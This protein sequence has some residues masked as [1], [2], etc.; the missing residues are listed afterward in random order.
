MHPSEAEQA[1]LQKLD[2]DVRLIMVNAKVPYDVIAR[3]ADLQY[4]S[5][6]DFVELY[7]DKAVLAGEAPDE[8]GFKPGSNGYD[9]GSSKRARIR[10]SQAWDTAAMTLTTRKKVMTAASNEEV[11]S[12]VTDATRSNMEKM[13]EADHGGKKPPL[14]R[15]GSDTLIGLLL[16]KLSAE[17]VP[18]L[19]EKQLVCKL[20][21][22][23]GNVVTSKRAADGTIREVEEEEGIPAAA[24]EEFEA[25]VE[26][27][28]TSYIMVAKTLPHI[29][30]IQVDEIRFEQF[31]RKFFGPLLARSTS[32]RPDLDTV[33]RAYVQCWREIV[34]HMHSHS[35]GVTQ[36]I[37]AV[38][39]DSLL[40]Q[41]L[42]KTTT[43]RTERRSHQPP[44]GRSAPYHNQPPWMAKPCGGSG[45]GSKSF[46]K[47]AAAHDKGKGKGKG[48]KPGRQK[49][50][51]QTW[52]TNALRTPP[53]AQHPNGQLICFD[54]HLQGTCAGR[55]GKNHD[56]CP[57]LLASGRFCFGTDHEGFRCPGPF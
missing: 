13:W 27:H 54:H 36:A 23:I 8:L 16:K 35:V 6:A 7:S 30:S 11:K 10:L 4:T 29:P 9:E 14:D 42:F 39:G 37:D 32:P 57:R 47:S 28:I 5:L 19:E 3:F 52:G 25:K 33:K 40:L 46:G 53:S 1:A 55:C 31:T 17:N 45:K 18:V 48:G 51:P 56:F 49:G 38:E 2:K 21:E 43:D 15:Q 20:D 26:T 12:L 41:H 24:L 50:V 22:N 44:P 34:K